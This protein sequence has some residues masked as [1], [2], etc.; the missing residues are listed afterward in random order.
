VVVQLGAVARAVDQGD[1]PAA[2][3]RQQVEHHGARARQARAAGQE[4]VA[5]VVL[6]VRRFAHEKT[7]VGTSQ[8]DTIA[9]PQVLVHPARALATG[10]VANVEFDLA[11]LRRGAGDREGARGGFARNVQPDVLPG[12]EGDGRV[13]LDPH[14]LDGGRQAL[15]ARHHPAVVLHQQVAGVGLFLDLGLDH[16]VGLRRGAAG[17]ALALLALVVHQ[18]KT[19]GF[20]VLDFA[21]GDLDLA[22]AAQAVAAGVR[23]VDAGAQ[24]GVENG[25]PFL[26]LDDLTDRFNGE[27]IAHGR[28]LLSKTIAAGACWTSAGAGFHSNS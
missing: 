23:Q 15:D 10:D 25:L 13:K 19:A 6:L 28:S 7:P 8:P 24:R 26:D 16:H 9:H 17:Q 2:G 3:G 20:A 22:G 4:Q 27:L 18:G 1:R 11:G 12:L 5:Q 14:A 21:I